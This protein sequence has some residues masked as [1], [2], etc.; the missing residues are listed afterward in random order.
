[1]TDHNSQ[2]DKSPNLTSPKRNSSSTKPETQSAAFQAVIRRPLWLSIICI[3][4]WISALVAFLFAFL[5]TKTGVIWIGVLFGVMAV[6]MTK[7]GIDFWHMRTRQW[8]IVFLALVTGA[9]YIASLFINSDVGLKE[10]VLH[11][12]FDMIGILVVYMCV[13]CVLLVWEHVK[14]L[15]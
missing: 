15:K 7:T 3:I 11:F 6:A 12:L 9:S 4:M 10:S 13:V 8:S 5:E 14:K 1:M 2:S